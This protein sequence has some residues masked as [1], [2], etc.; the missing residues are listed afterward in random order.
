MTRSA[1]LTGLLVLVVAECPGSTRPG[2]RPVPALGSPCSARGQREQS[3][4]DGAER[5]E[6][7][8]VGGDARRLG[9]G[10]QPDGADVVVGRGLSTVVHWVTSLVMSGWGDQGL[11]R[12]SSTWSARLV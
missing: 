12:C 1:V 7:R 4:R 2:R 5:R 11:A 9:C 10:Q 6:G 8:G 3:G